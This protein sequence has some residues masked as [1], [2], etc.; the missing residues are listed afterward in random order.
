MA[1]WGVGAAVLRKEDDR[2]LRGQGQYVGDVRIPG[3]QEVAFVRS[4]V[5]HARLKRI[6]VPEKFRGCVFTADHL[7]GIK[8]IISA[9]PL[10]GFKYSVQPILATGKLR[11]VGEMIAMCV[12]PTRAH[13]ED[14]ASAISLEFEELP[15]VTDMIAAC[16]PASPLVHEEW[17]DNIF[18][19]LG[20][21]RWNDDLAKGAAIKINKKI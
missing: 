5:A 18:I 15:A 3:M 20:E 19:E 16:Q 17:G 9:P 13:A 10:K 2:F 14:I 11:Y 4:P 8:P 21:N 1:Q 7:G 12:A 6:E